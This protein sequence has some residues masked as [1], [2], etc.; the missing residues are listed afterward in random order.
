VR[1]SGPS[2]KQQQQN[3]LLCTRACK[4]CC[5]ALG[6][7]LQIQRQLCCAVWVDQ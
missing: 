6:L 2:T 5:C 7:L 3:H 1:T 4:R